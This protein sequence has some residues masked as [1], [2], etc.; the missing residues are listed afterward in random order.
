MKVFLSW[1]GATSHKVACAFREW[2]PMVIQSVVPYVSSEDI[3]KGARWST[4]I[5]KELE[6]SRYGII[7]VTRE[8]ILA[9]WV[10]FEAGALSKI[11]DKSHVTPFLFDLKR[12][13][14]QGPLLQFQSTILEGDDILKL[15]QS[16]NNRATETERLRDETL[17]KSFEVWWPH[18]ENSLTAVTFPPDVQANAVIS[19][20]DKSQDI[21]EELLDL[22]RGQQRLLT[23]PPALLPVE[24]LRWA[25]DKVGSHDPRSL[26]EERMILRRIHISMMELEEL[27]RNRSEGSEVFAEVATLVS[28]IHDHFHRLPN[29]PTNQVRLPKRLSRISRV[30]D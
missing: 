23:T 26:A 13:D 8:N 6:D 4:D 18:L 1:S 21:L 9:P 20:K 3:D 27:V 28:R 11:I 29:W 30:E 25:L 10:N 14:V 5:A 12:S 15:L 17:R 7:C 16:I 2:L 24:Y 19:D 22:A